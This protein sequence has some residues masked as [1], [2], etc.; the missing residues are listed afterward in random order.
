MKKKVIVVRT[1]AFFTQYNSYL[2]N[3]KEWVG[4]IELGYALG[5]AGLSPQ[6]PAIALVGT[7]ITVDCVEIPEGGATIDYRNR[8]ITFKNGG[9]KNLGVEI[10]QPGMSL[11]GFA[12]QIVAFAQ[13]VAPTRT[14]DKMEAPEVIEEPEVVET[15]ID[16]AE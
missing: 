2:V 3:G 9:E 5:N 11:M 10:T 6:T 4:G 15:P 8:T 12:A 13:P 7:T 14:S 1:I 16:D